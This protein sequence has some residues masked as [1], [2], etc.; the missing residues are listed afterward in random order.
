MAAPFV[1]EVRIWACNFAPTG[2]ALCAGQLLP[3]SQNT[4][5]FSLI[6]T[7]YGG[8]GKSTFALPNFQGNV[9]IHQGQGPGLSEYFLGEQGGSQTVT[10]INTE[11]PSHSHSL[12]ADNGFGSGAD[13]TNNLYE[14][15]QWSAPPNTGTVPAYTSAAPN[16]QLGPQAIAP[17]GGSNPHNNMMP[18]LTLNFTIALQGIYPARN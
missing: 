5:L 8:D 14:A 3:I 2:W 16:T 4:A 7:F 11:I 1:A 18:Y 15:G 6:G 17:A 13:P 9:P 12:N 10:L